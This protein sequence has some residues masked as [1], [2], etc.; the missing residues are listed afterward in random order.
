M[1]NKLGEAGVDDGT[2]AY[3]LTT[4]LV[5]RRAM[6]LYPLLRAATSRDDVRREMSA[7]IAEEAAHKGPLEDAAK[8]RLAKH[9]GE[10]LSLEL[11]VAEEEALFR[12]WLER[13][14]APFVSTAPAAAPTRART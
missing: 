9:C 12:R 2:L 4:T 1:A 8:V 13:M 5:E 10:T 11:F 6:M 3:L 14:E 7:I